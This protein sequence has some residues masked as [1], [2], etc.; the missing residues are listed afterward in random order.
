[1][2]AV[3]PFLAAGT[4]F[5]A[6]VIVGLLAGVWLDRHFGTAYWVLV[7]LFAGFVLGAFGAWRLVA[8]SL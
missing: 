1:M 8:R 5:A 4:T 3:A 2:N 7:M 6:T